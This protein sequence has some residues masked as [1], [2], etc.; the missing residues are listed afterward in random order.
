MDL[1]QPWVSARRVAGLVPARSRVAGGRGKA[2]RHRARRQEGG[3]VVGVI[4]QQEMSS[5]RICL[6]VGD[7]D[8]Q[9]R[10]GWRRRGRGSG[11]GGNED[12]D[13]G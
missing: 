13:E 11:G 1:A 8:V 3:V 9:G 5:V 6:F 10:I 12:K 2:W 4:E 7:V